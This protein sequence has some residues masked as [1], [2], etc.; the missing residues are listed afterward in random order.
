LKVS[1]SD[2]EVTN[3]GTEHYKPL[4]S[5]ETDIDGKVSER[6]IMNKQGRVFIGYQQ[7][8]TDNSTRESIRLPEK[9]EEPRKRTSVSVL[10]N[11][12][13]NNRPR[14]M[15]L[16]TDL[17]DRNRTGI[18]E[19]QGITCS[20]LTTATSEPTRILRMKLNPKALCY[21]P[22][23][24]VNFQEE[25][26]M[27]AEV[28]KEHIQAT[29]HIP[30][31]DTS[32]DSPTVIP[33]AE[34]TPMV[35]NLKG[36]S[37]DDILRDLDALKNDPDIPM[38][39]IEADLAPAEDFEQ[40]SKSLDKEESGRESIGTVEE[41]LDKD[42]DCLETLRKLT[43]SGLE[44]FRPQAFPIDLW[45][46]VFNDQKL[47]VKER[48]TGYDEGSLS[49]LIEEFLQELQVSDERP[50]AK[51]YFLAQA[52]A[53]L[54]RFVIKSK[55]GIPPLIDEKFTHRMELLPGTRVRKELPQRFSENQNA[56][57]KAKLAILEEQGR[58]KQKDGLRKED[59]LH[60]LVLVENPTRMAAFRL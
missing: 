7:T 21:V 43:G 19:R 3:Y 17:M 45:P 25:M 35:W 1:E 47:L 31:S 23:R 44:E 13:G 42:S 55:E 30:I 22:K 4:Q 49:R 34:E 15:R 29:D 51:P 59:W 26:T 40:Y 9:N 37:I 48:W 18:S 53:N 24:R 32:R 5:A 52:L 58:I 10:Q 12:L 6:E 60:R 27:T 41:E 54:D 11:I 38:P 50:Y 56:F 16:D 39:I 20:T 28:D 8:L 2:W 33:K 46:Y 36:R 57:L 14:W